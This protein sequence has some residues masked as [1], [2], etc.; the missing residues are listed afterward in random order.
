MLLYK[1]GCF[2]DIF[3]VCIDSFDERDS[4]DDVLVRLPKFFYVVQN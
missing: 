3:F 4:H 2:V 1:P